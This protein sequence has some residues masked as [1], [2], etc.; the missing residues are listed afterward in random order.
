[1]LIT[2]TTQTFSCTQ[3][4]PISISPKCCVVEVAGFGIHIK[5]ASVSALTGNAAVVGTSCKA[6]VKFHRS[7]SAI[8]GHANGECTLFWRTEKEKEK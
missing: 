6:S 8:Q 4:H 5:I 7:T 2:D 1:M 3:Y